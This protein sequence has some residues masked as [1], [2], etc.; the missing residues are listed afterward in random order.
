MEWPYFTAIIDLADR[1]VVVRPLSDTMKT[2]DYQ[3]RCLEDGYQKQA[4]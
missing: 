1:K 3:Y 2:I 4:C